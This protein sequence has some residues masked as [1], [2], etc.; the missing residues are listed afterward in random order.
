MSNHGGERLG[1]GRPNLLG[2]GA[3]RSRRTIKAGC[4][5]YIVLSLRDDIPSMR[6]NDLYKIFQKALRRSKCFDLRVIHFSVLHK[7]IHL[8]VETKNNETLNSG[9]KSLTI[10]LAKNINSWVS[11]YHFPRKGSVFFGRYRLRVLETAKE[12]RLFTQKVLLAAGTYFKKGPYQDPRSSNIIFK[13]WGR[14]LKGFKLKKQRF[15]KFQ[16]EIPPD[17][18][19]IC[20]NLLSKARYR[21][22]TCWLC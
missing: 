10:K 3:H 2:E 20:K 6:K 11:Y 5:L 13:N 22:T 4:P 8:I 19:I 15:S 9:I 1:A 12:V 17:D 18:I 16:V 7:K 21:L 14:L